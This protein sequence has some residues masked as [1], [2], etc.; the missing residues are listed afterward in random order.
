[1]ASENRKDQAAAPEREPAKDLPSSARPTPHGGSR[2]INDGPESP[3][4]N[5]C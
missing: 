4:S 5:L 3:R 2:I 1:M